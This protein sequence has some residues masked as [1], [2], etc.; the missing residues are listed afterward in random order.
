MT[1]FTEAKDDG[2]IDE[3]LQMSEREFQMML[4]GMIEDSNAWRLHQEKHRNL[5]D[6]R[7]VPTFQ[8]EASEFDKR[9]GEHSK[10]SDEQSLI[11]YHGQGKFTGGCMCGARFVVDLKNDKVEQVDPNLKMKDLPKYNRENNQEQQYGREQP[12][13]TKYNMGPKPIQPSPG[14]DSSGGL[15]YKN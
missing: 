11:Q 2:T 3:K 6:A 7:I 5:K 4:Q 14:Y 13:G 9:L 8:E 1:F 12:E 10:K 15:K